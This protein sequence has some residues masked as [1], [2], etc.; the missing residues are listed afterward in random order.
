MERS[1]LIL[2]RDDVGRSCHLLDGRRVEP[3]AVLELL[4][5]ARRWLRCQYR[6]NGDPD[7]QPVFSVVL[8]GEWES[9][10]LG[11]PGHFD[12]APEAIVRIELADALWR[13]PV[14]D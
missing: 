11:D 4:L 2:G 13:W 8:G 6:W 1:R 5:S 3:H 7:S 12:R 9:R 10:A 14:S